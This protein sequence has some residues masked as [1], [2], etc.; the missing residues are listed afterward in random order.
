MYLKKLIQITQIVFLFWKSKKFLINLQFHSHPLLRGFQS[1]Q[2]KNNNLSKV[3]KE[4]QNKF[5]KESIIVSQD[6]TKS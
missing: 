4:Y 6:C 1:S 5:N 2:K 3:S